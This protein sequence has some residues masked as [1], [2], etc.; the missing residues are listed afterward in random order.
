MKGFRESFIEIH[1]EI[2]YKGKC[3]LQC[4]VVGTGL[5]LSVRN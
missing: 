4:S 1:V 2:E 5:S 3:L